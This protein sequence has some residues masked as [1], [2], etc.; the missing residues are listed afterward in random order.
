MRS[1]FG[2]VLAVS[3]AAVVGC[4]SPASH[5]KSDIETATSAC[6]QRQ[7]MTQ[8]ELVQCTDA[9]E[10][11]V[12]YRD[13]PNLLSAYDA[14][15]SA[16]LSAA[17]DYDKQVKLA[18]EKAWISAKSE[19]DANWMKASKAVMGASR[20]TQSDKDLLNHE[21]IEAG[22]KCVKD[23][24]WKAATAVKFFQCEQTARLPVFE[25]RVP[26]AVSSVQAYYNE[27]LAIA[28][29]Y[30]RIVSSIR[31]IAAAK[32]HT[33]I[34]PPRRTLQLQVQVAVQNDAAATARQRQELADLL[35]VLALGALV[36]VGGAAEQPSH[37]PI[38][39]SC[40]T[41][42]PTTNCLSY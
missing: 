20:L 26:A 25:Q 22:A 1:G 11:P 29:D 10:R 35:A 40:T 14:W 32:L 15:N 36:V 5:F 30:D 42:G 8:T 4:A 19:I 39:T 31:Q 28:A 41:T 21:L 6:K 34:D 33:A 38:P 2:G 12:V 18:I 9:A 37:Q 23:G 3:M 24:K 27:G 16:R 13:L 17:N 7:F